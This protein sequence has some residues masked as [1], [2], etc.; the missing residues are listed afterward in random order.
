MA[1][2]DD[3]NAES[4]FRGYLS[5]VRHELRTPINAMIGYSEMLLDDS[6]E[7]TGLSPVLTELLQQ[8][9]ANSKELLER[10][11]LYLDPARLTPDASQRSSEVVETARLHLTPLIQGIVH[12]TTQ[13]VNLTLESSEDEALL[14]DTQKIDGA[15]GRFM[16]MLEQMPVFSPQP[17]GAPEAAAAIESS[18]APEEPP[19]DTPPAPGGRLL[20]VDDVE[21]N[22]DVL[23][24]Q[25][26]KQGHTITTAINGREALERVACET[27]DLVLLDLMMPELDGFEVLQRLKADPHTQAIPVIMISALDELEGV[28]RCIEMGA[29]DYLPKPFNPVILRA[30]VGACLEKKRLHDQEQAYL[31]QVQR[32]IAAAAAVE[33]NA[34]SPGSLDEVAARSDALGQ[35][36]RVFQGLFKDLQFSHARLAEAYDITLEGWAHALE[37]RDQETEGHCRRVTDLTVTLC[38]RLGVP[39]NDLIHVRRGALLHDI[40]KMGIPDAILLKPGPLTD[41]ER[42]IMQRHTE[43]GYALLKP[44]KYLSPA[45]DIPYCHHEKWNGTGYPRQLKET[46][47]PLAARAFAV[48][49]VWDALTSDRPYRAAWPKEKAQA[50]IVK[51]AGSHFDPWVVQEFLTLIK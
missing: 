20:I 38:R 1:P 28:V 44:I 15:A 49:D 21:T 17:K 40:G 19:A 37:L 27:F 35:F 26:Q 9:I 41:E 5:Q 22:R 11:N 25:L 34:F 47:I 39:E 14:S 10:V 29:E 2:S 30:R 48:I 45:V 4:A 46:S 7:E 50:L 23:T 18:A 8:V 16:L 13:M 36:A 33:A 51:D 3:L 42:S 32:V 43:Y 24:R 12:T 6:N 31:E